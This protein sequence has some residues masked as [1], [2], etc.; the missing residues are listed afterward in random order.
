MFERLC[1]LTAEAAEEPLL[2][3]G[4]LRRRA[5]FH[6]KD[7]VVHGKS[8]DFAVDAWGALLRQLRA[9]SVAQSGLTTA[10]L[11]LKLSSVE[12]L[13]SPELMVATRP[14]G[15][16]SAQLRAVILR[17]LGELVE[18]TDQAEVVIAMPLSLLLDR[19]A[20]ARLVHP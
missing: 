11:P 12:E 10:A 2:R 15:L 17:V 7:L 13:L 20:T 6:A 3:V 9:M 5:D 8:L 1:R 19:A 18:Q 4:P 14:Y 16:S